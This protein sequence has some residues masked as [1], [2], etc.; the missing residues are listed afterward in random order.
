M[1]DLAL[2]VYGFSQESFVDGPGIRFVIFTQGCENACPHCHN[3]ASWD[4]NG[5]KRYTTREVIKMIKNAAKRP[6]K[7][8]PQADKKT[9]CGKIQGVTFSGGEPFMQAGALIPVAQA[10]KSM[11]LDITTYTGHVYEDLARHAD[12]DV[13]ALLSLTDYLIDGP[14]IYSKRDIGMKFR[15]SSNQRIIDMNETRKAGFV[16]ECSVFS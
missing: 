16:V 11:G 13:K 8:F 14:F 7:A 1:S 3:P 4:I 2:R 15:G 6:G 5:G 9:P 12:E 10:V